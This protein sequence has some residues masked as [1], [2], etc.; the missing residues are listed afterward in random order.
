M[1]CSIL[2]FLHLLSYVFVEN[3]SIANKNKALT[4]VLFLDKRS[5]EIVAEKIHYCS[6]LILRTLPIFGRKGIEGHVFDAI[7]ETVIAHFL[8][9]ACTNFMSR[10]SWHSSFF[11]PSSGAVHNK[12]DVIRNV[13]FK[14]KISILKE[15]SLPPINWNLCKSV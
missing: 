15:H 3:G 9:N 1:F 14:R 6:Y 8:K 10:L 11:S 5:F 2:K 7:F 13:A 4:I 12:R